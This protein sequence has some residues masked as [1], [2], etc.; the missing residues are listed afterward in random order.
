[1]G[2]GGGGRRG[3]GALTFFLGRYVQHHGSR[4][5]L[6]LDNFVKYYLT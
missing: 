5:T 1:M 2:G 6:V 4:P 3:M